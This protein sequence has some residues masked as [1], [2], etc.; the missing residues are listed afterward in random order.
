MFKDLTT[1]SQLLCILCNE[2]L[3]EQEYD[4]RFTRKIN[5]LEPI[6]TVE[7]A[8]EAYVDVRKGHLVI[9]FHLYLRN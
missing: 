7:R 6:L 8:D 1:Y 3:S 4:S 2:T 5:L 9:L